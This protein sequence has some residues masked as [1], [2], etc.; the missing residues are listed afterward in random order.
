MHEVTFIPGKGMFINGERQSADEA[1]RTYC[2]PGAG[3][4]GGSA[5]TTRARAAEFN[6]RD[7]S[8]HNH[9][10]LIRAGAAKTVCR[11]Q[12]AHDTHYEKARRDSSHESSEQFGAGESHGVPSVYAATF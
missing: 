10:D 12:L 9:D 3:G 8:G 1:C 4:A 11:P 5:A 6:L 7:S 2:L